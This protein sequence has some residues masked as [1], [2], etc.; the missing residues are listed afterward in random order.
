MP[1]LTPA[2]PNRRE[3]GDIIIATFPNFVRSLWIKV[4]HKQGKKIRPLRTSTVVV[5]ENGAQSPHR[6]DSWFLTVVENLGSFRRSTDVGA[7]FRELI[8]LYASLILSPSSMSSA[9]TEAGQGVKSGLSIGGHCTL[10]P[11]PTGAISD[12]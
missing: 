3:I 2:Y 5:N 1:S 12:S 7:R 4:S 11:E 6:E 10:P 8:G 9:I